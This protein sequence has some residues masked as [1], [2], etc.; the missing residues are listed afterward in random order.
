MPYCAPKGNAR[1]PLH[2]DIM[3]GAHS[4]GRGR[5]GGD[6]AAAIRRGVCRLLADMGYSVLTEFE[7]GSGRR[8]DVAGVNR[9]GMF[10]I[11]EIKS[12]LADFKSDGKWPD[13]LSYCDNF[14]FA[15]AEDFPR[16]A[17][18]ESAGRPDRCGLIVADRYGGA[19]LRHAPEVR[20]NASRRR[21]ELLRFARRAAS[22]LQNL[23]DPA[24]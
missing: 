16:H 12:S 2:G 3:T 22:R 10:V 7:L 17:L 21:G 14:Y 5:K 19:V 13:Y 18:M 20:M 8:A 9:K 24:A 4:K 6:G 23:A 1:E 15:V 11:A